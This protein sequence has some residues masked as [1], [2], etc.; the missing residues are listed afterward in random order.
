MLKT[1]MVI[2]RHS[3][4]ISL[5]KR[6]APSHE[7]SMKKKTK[8]WQCPNPPGSPLQAGVQ[9]SHTRRADSFMPLPLVK[10]SVHVVLKFL[11]TT[12]MIKSVD[13]SAQ[14]LSFLL[15]TWWPS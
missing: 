8:S 12:K 13:K 4:F 1:H 3:V 11:I 15:I 14:N 10:P 7:H 5:G 9:T 2:H 6:L